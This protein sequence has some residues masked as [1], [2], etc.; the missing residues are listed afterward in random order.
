MR[1]RLR[2]E[3]WYCNSGEKRGSINLPLKAKFC[4][5]RE[6][7]SIHSSAYKCLWQM[8]HASVA[9][10]ILRFDFLLSSRAV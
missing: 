3:A 6:S 4:P 9:L 7:L 2:P 5:L 1:L 10:K 8:C